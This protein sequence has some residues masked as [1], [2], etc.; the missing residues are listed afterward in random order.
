MGSPLRPVGVIDADV[1]TCIAGRLG[2]TPD[3][4]P[5]SMTV[6]NGPGTAPKTFNVQVV[7]Q[8]ALLA[9]LVLT[10]LTNSVDME[11]D[12]P[13]DLT[14]EMRCTIAVEG[15]APVVFEDTYSGVS[16]SGGRAPAAL[17]SPVAAVVSLLAYNAYQPVRLQRIDCTTTLRPGRRTAE[18][19]AVELDS[20]TVAPGA[21]LKATVTLKPYQ[22]PRQR[23]R[24]ELPLPADLPEGGYSAT[25][26]DGPTQARTHLREHPELSSPQTLEQILAALRVQTSARRTQLVIRVPTGP[27]GVALDDGRTLPDLPAGLAH[28]LGQSRRGG[29]R[30]V[31]GA[32]LARTPTDWVI[33]GSEVVKFTVRKPQHVTSED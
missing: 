17:Y 3:L 9:P 12:L 2:R 32:L 15:Q 5:L 33:Q 19:E 26:C 30:P 14:A 6:C 31:A 4:M 1:S 24:V 23:L 8:R 29:A 22:G 7:R 21:A 10:A 18:I 16:V 20:D 27:S 28:A 13:E 25:V 11:G